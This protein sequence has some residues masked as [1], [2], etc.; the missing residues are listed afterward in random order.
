MPKITK[1]PASI[2]RYTSAP[3]DAPVKRKVAAYARVSTDSEEQLTSYAAQISYYTEYIKG[4]EDW[5]FV[6][7]YTD[8][9]ISGCSTKRREGFQRMISD[10]MAGKID[11]IITKSVSRFARNTV[12]SLTTIR[13]LKENNVE[14]YFEKENIWTFDGKGELLLTI[15]SSISQEEA[16]SISENVTWGHR[17]RFAD[18]KV[19]VAYSRFLGYDKGSDGKMVVNPEQAEIV[20][21]IYRLLLEGMTPH[22][23]AI[24]LTEKGIKTPGGK[25]KW[26][27]TTIRRILTNEKYK[28]D[29]LLQ[30]EFT[31]D[32]LTKKTKK[33]CGEIPMYYIEDDHEAIIDPAVFDMVQQEMERRK[34]GTSRY[35]GVSIF[36]SKIK[37]G[38]CGGWYG[39]KVW[40]STDQY[41]KVIYRCN[42][43]YN[44]ER[45]TTPHIMEEEVKAVFLKSLNKL[46]ANRDELIENVKLICD[47]LTNTSELEAEKEKYAG[48][49]SLVAD[50]VQAAMLENARIALDQEEYRQKND[51]LSARFEAAKKKHDELAM[52]IEEI[53]TR[54]QNLRHFQETLES[55]NGQVTEF[56][57]DLWGS[58]VGYITVYENGE[59]TV[60][61]RDGSVI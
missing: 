28:G 34:T 56:D 44:D 40:H 37:C 31:V 38:E 16:R 52:R 27:A 54:G 5:E 59:K 51:V 18:G 23:I 13:L 47:K 35:S 48:E 53:E 36:S 15:M 50:M 6:G 49:M 22:T 20:K 2:S 29:A 11:L 24:H 57:S 25:D 32:F 14:C 39:A 33:N 3:I 21:L 41:R 10:A 58:L 55:L 1:I 26:N 17:K 8:E 46:L 60:T 9:G 12:D 42:N 43:K 30:K 19:S 4:R 7:V 45:C 61:F